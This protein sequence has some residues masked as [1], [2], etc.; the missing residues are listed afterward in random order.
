MD[1]DGDN[2]DNKDGNNG[3]DVDDEDDG[4]KGR[5]GGGYGGC[6]GE[7]GKRKRGV[8][9]GL[10]LFIRTPKLTFSR[11]RPVMQMHC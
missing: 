7:G 3:D 6:G 4:G 1:N 10:G 11:K 8:L 9:L 2:D 5:Q